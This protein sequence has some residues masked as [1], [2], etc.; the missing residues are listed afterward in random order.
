MKNK[1]LQLTTSL[2]FLYCGIAAQT[3][4]PDLQDTSKWRLVNRTAQPINEEGKRG[5]RLSET[6]ND[7]IE[8]SQEYRVETYNHSYY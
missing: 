6:Q 3:I 5:I 2:L 7:G 4:T 1:F 8:M